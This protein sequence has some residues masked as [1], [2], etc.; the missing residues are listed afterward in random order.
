MHP[1]RRSLHILPP[2]ILAVVL[3]TIYLLTM[4]PGLTW[5]NSGADG[6]DL[7]SAAATG[8][9]AHPTGYPTFLL[10]ARFF[11]FLPIGS[12]AFRTNL[13]S[14][15][16]A[17]AAS[18]LVYHL[19]IRTLAPE[20]PYRYWL[21]GLAAG[22]GFGLAPLLWSQAVIT[23]VYAL[24]SL[25][26]ALL[27]YLSGSPMTPPLKKSRKDFLLG[28]TFGLALGNHITILFL[29]PIVLFE[30]HFLGNGMPKRIRWIQNLRFDKKS[31]LLRL[32]WAAIGLL[33][34]LSLP[35]RALSHPPV[36]WGN[37][38]T[39]AGFEWL[40]TGKLYQDHFLVSSFPILIERLR[41]VAAIFLDNL[42]VIG[43][44]ISLVGLVVYFKPTRLYFS[45]LWI[46]GVFSIFSIGYAT[47]DSFVYLIPAEISLSIWLGIGAGRLMDA[48][49]RRRS[50]ISFAAGLAFLLVL[51][52][53]AGLH[54]THVDASGDARA[55]KF[56]EDVLS[57]APQDA[58]VFAKGDQAI[59]SLW[60]FQYA[61]HERPDLVV[62]ASDM[63]QFDWYLQTLRST[64]PA[65]DLSEPFPFPETVI[66][67]NPDR[68]VC[69][70]EY[71][72]APLINCV[73]P[74]GFAMPPETGGRD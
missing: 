9:V 73:P 36:N 58:I 43:L 48:V 74:R 24:N 56:G 14:A 27:L 59:F 55:E 57:I 61:L 26:V 66:V 52:I 23:E 4:A 18:V 65:M 22:F 45:L 3:M 62:I 34:Y 7:I 31:V 47:N 32:L 33:I 11:Q 68:Y 44:T 29:F 63:L 1:C 51:F 42:G 10:I 71:S 41:A 30:T 12:L 38:V 6:G 72:Q 40:V 20:S 67:L 35:L 53:Q 64:Y 5:A 70:V 16:A 37:P 17:T 50:S 8:G 2:L 46:L 15:L 25:F 19:T 13:L 28:L 60:Y 49:A 69:Y 54:W 21:P 39:P